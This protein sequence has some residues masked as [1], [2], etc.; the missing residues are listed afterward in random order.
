[1]ITAMVVA[2]ARARAQ[3]VGIAREQTIPWFPS[4]G[5]WPSKGRTPLCAKARLWRAMKSAESRRVRWWCRQDRRRS[6]PMVSSACRS[7]ATATAT[8][9]S[10]DGL[11]GRPR[12]PMAPS[13][14]GLVTKTAEAK[15]TKWLGEAAEAKVGRPKEKVV[16][17]ATATQT[18]AR[19]RVGHMAMVCKLR[20][21]RERVAGHMAEVKVLRSVELLSN[22]LYCSAY[23]VASLFSGR[24]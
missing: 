3:M 2:K 21:A 15:A 8:A 4:H 7:S 20:A 6:V 19:E 5:G 17:M 14:S 18:A 13:S 22:P 11:R 16:G 23:V 12:R 24:V 9:S 10:G 1:M